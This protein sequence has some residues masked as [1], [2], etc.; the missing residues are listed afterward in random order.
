MRH[1]RATWV[2]LFADLCWIPCALWLSYQL[3]YGFSL[4]TPFFSDPGLSLMACFMAGTWLLLFDLLSAD[5]F[6]GGWQLAATISRVSTAVFLLMA[7]VGTWG[8]AQQLYFSRLMLLYLSIVLWMGFLGVR[9]AANAVLLR[10][11]QAGKTRRVVLIGDGHVGAELIARIE[12]HPELLFEIVGYLNP[13]KDVTSTTASG[14]SPG[15]PGLG[16]LDAL[17][18]LKKLRVDE[19]I[20]AAQ[21]LPAAELG[22]FLPRCRSEGIRVSFLPPS[23]ELYL[24]RARLMDIDG[25]PLI[26]LEQPPYSVLPRL[27]KRAM[28]LVLG[29]L[30]L[31]P[32]LPIMAV[33][34]FALWLKEGRLF[35]R[36]VRCG[37][38]G[39]PFHLF[40]MDVALAP[41][42]PAVSRFLRL[43][44]ISELPQ[45]LNVL[46]GQMSL[47]GPR[48][49]PPSRVTYYSEWQKQ[50]LKTM[51]GM[52]G[53]AQV[54]GLRDLHS[55]ED[56]ARYDLQ[57][58]LRWTPVFDVIL[59]VQTVWMILLR[60]LR[61]PAGV[62]FT[63]SSR[64]HAP[65]GFAAAGQ[66]PAPPLTD[67]DR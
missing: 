59:L 5:G 58:I 54:N 1:H 56:K 26:S 14:T 45:L 53:L 65:Q 28:D 55:S 4:S 19:V 31:V 13:M 57:Y 33:G 32:A 66:E 44:N 41:D 27:V 36:E 24:T 17:Q 64:S 60:L 30:L 6:Q 37:L 62:H 22:R 21:Q 49:E 51:P 8:Y 67:R 40:R 43:T 35:R 48:P 7:G 18:L 47:V 52:T 63:S 50:R 11:H 42:A 2:V 25:L 23:Y 38:N 15:P 3:R 10:L 34:A 39:K 20:V 46:R 29:L 16:S 12:R 9:V 61:L